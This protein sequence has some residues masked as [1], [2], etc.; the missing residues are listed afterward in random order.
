[1]PID[2]DLDFYRRQIQDACDLK[3]TD[4]KG[5]PVSIRALADEEKLMPSID[6]HL[7][8]YEKLIENTYHVKLST[9]K[10]DPD[11]CRAKVISNTLVNGSRY[12]YVDGATPMLMLY[13]MDLALQNSAIQQVPAP[14][15]ALN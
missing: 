1:M 5:N 2:H 12:F 4:Y 14:I 10:E 11:S 3:L 8:V 7:G 13:N 6:H 15:H 9:Y